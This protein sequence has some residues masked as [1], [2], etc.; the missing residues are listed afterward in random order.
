MLRSLVGSEMCIRDRAYREGLKD[1]SAP[2][3]IALITNE[4]KGET[5]TNWMLKNQ[6]DL[7][8]GTVYDLIFIG[9]DLAGNQT[10]FIATPNITYDITL[11]VFSILDPIEGAYANYLSISYELSEPLK[12]GSI[13]WTAFCFKKR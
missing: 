6:T 8:D 11:P 12:D 3:V 1:T 9:Q 13:T 2:H 7:V 4:R 10:G 5:R